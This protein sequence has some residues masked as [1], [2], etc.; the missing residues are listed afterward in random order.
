MGI[1]V[2]DVAG[3][4]HPRDDLMDPA[5]A[6]IGSDG[7]R[8]GHLIEHPRDRRRG[9]SSAVEHC[10]GDRRAFKN[11]FLFLLCP[12]FLQAHRDCTLLAAVAL[13]MDG[14]AFFPGGCILVLTDAVML[15][16]QQTLEG[17]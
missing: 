15:K 10:Q 1:E 16:V 17:L 5:P 9:H 3:S 12:R 6:P 13:L 8:H 14:R 4:V 11:Q 2:E 7:H